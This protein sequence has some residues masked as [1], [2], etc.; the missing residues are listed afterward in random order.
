[1]I[2]FFNWLIII[3]VAVVA[4]LLLGTTMVIVSVS[5]AP[6]TDDPISEGAHFI[7]TV[8][9]TV[10]TVAGMGAAIF[11]KIKGSMKNSERAAVQ[12]A[13]TFI[14]NYVVPVLEEGAKV[15]EKTQGQEEKLKQFGQVLYGF[16]GDKA[17]EITNKDAIKLDALHHDVTIADGDTKEYHDKII[18]LQTMAKELGIIQQQS[19]SFT[20]PQPAAPPPPTT[21]VVATTKPPPTIVWD[22]ATKTWISK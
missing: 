19:S 7:Q 1:M 10:S 17:N 20:P 12:K 3:T 22:E 11:V 4:M 13:G 8:V 15:A 18:R 14:E 2:F 21:K 9:I 5:A 6:T 16:M